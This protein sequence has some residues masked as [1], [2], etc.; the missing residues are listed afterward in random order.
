MV[1][2]D[3]DVVGLETAPDAGSGLIF[4]KGATRRRHAQD[5]F[6]NEEVQAPEVWPA[7][8]P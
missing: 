3:I 2:K 6:A 7:T 8:L 4:P 1:L 5:G